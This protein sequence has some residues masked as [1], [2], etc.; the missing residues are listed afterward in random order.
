MVKRA[1]RD[2]RIAEV[3]EKILVRYAVGERFT[4]LSAAGALDETMYIVYK[5]L[6]DIQVSSREECPDCVQ[7]QMNRRCACMFISNQDS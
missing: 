2:R 1:E 5:A 3:R 4:V 7:L 6:K